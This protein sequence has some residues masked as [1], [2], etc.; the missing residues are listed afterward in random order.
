MGSVHGLTSRGCVAAAFTGIRDLVQRS[1]QGLL[2]E[3]PRCSQ[4]AGFVVGVCLLFFPLAAPAQAAKPGQDVF[5]A[6]CMGCHAI[7]CNRNG[8]KLAGALGRTAGSVADFNA[9]TGGMK[10]AGFVWSRDRL[11]KFLAD[12]GAMVPGTSMASVVRLSSATDRRSVI[13]FIASGDKSLDLC[14]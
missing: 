11:D 9:Y 2:A 14:F 8:P 10:A 5:R 12:P 6:R 4:A 3:K 1:K 13:D 7:A